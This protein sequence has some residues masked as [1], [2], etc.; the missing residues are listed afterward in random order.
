MRVKCF[1]DLYVSGLL[2]NKENKVIQNLMEEKLQPMIQVITLARGEQNH[3]E[4]FSALLLKQHIY[5]DQELFVVGL[6]DGYEDAL[7]LVEEIAQDVLEKT[8]G[9]D[10]RGYITA[11]Q[12]EF[13]K[14]RA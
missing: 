9:T 7:Y 8:N 13:E 1:C 11:R 14:G 5:E 2:K 4:F 10:I 6:A 12:N 3:L